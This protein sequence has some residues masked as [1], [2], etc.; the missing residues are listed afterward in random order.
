MVS[1]HIETDFVAITIFTVLFIKAV[2]LNK[3]KTFTDK[4]FC[5]ALFLGI[6]ST[7]VDIFSSTVMN[8]LTGWW[9]YE[10]GMILYGL[11]V[12][13][14]TIVWVIYT[15]SLLYLRE[16]GKA[17]RT[18][19]LF[20]APYFIYFLIVV[21]NPIHELMFSLSKDMVYARGP[22]FIP[23][24]A[25]SQ[26]FYAFLG[27]M[28]VLA[29]W[30]RI[31]PKSTAVLL[32][33]LYITTTA[34]YWIQM[35]FPGW[36]I[37]CSAYAA[38]FMICDATFESER[39]D[40]LYQ[41]VNQSLS[42]TK[43][44]NSELEK[45]NEM[46]QSEMNIISAISSVFFATYSIDLEH[47]TFTEVRSEEKTR[48]VV[49][50]E[51]AADK[52][53]ELIRKYLVSP[54][55]EE[56]EREFLEL[57]TLNERM[58]N[59]IIISDEFL[60]KDFGWLRSNFVAQERDG[61]G[62]LKKV[63]YVTREIG[64][65]KEKELA[66]QEKLEKAVKEANR[67]NR[68]KT[69]FLSRM[70]HDI[71]TPI[72]GIMGMLEIIRKNR[73]N[74]DKV[75]DC[76][77]KIET[78]SG[79]LLSLLNDVLDMSKLESGEAVIAQEPFDIRK[80]FEGCSEIAQPI[81]ADNGIKLIEDR[82]KKITHPY[83]IGSPTHLRQILINII[84]NAIKYNK[85]S[86]SVKCEWEEIASTDETVIYQFIITDT[87]QGMSEE[88]LQHI[89]EPFSQEHGEGRS[90]YRGTGLGLAIVKEL[91]DR[92]QGDISVESKLGEGS[93]FVVTLT[94]PLDKNPPVETGKQEEQEA[95]SD[96]NGIKILLVEDNE[97][98][99]E[100][101][102]FMLEEAGAVPE[103]ADNGRIAVEK[104]EKSPVGSYGAVLMDVMMPEMDG[105]TATK[106]IRSMKREDAKSIPII[107]MTANAFV[108]DME[109]CREAGMNVHLSKPLDC[110]TL[111]RTLQDCIRKK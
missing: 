65:E 12:P 24:G 2:W 89:F 77:D 17:K 74:E 78:S 36:L 72:N 108:E 103:V 100:I 37:I 54:E 66:Y 51:G 3:Q 32:L 83:L 88:Y 20:L 98:N 67:A 29:S 63:L 8:N 57:S 109:K 44:V 43:Q 81:A 19:A 60:G 71:R 70:S 33:G 69:A 82:E 85:A 25:G 55:Y 45:T 61:K 42:D 76:L 84:S 6:C 26:M 101:C 106:L 27:T 90:K 15:V 34:A 38:A 30:K 105:L 73:D 35:A 52:A 94:F 16:E 107:A 47:N 41:T 110:A 46:L 14:L 53:L 87:G 91:I 11:F 56:R 96:L 22:L 48:Q 10:I 64:E 39:R 9:P 58:K 13:L 102:V 31:Q 62:T 50:G 1:W 68:A 75:D 23:L 28:L 40:L 5:L 79:Y 111:L 97:L 86:G 80:V 4:T 99:Q 18:I 59:R 49:G 95:L 7:I 104:F 92:M 93:R 21:T